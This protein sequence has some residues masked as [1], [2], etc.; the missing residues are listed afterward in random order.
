MNSKLTFQIH[1]GQ[2]VNKNMIGNKYCA[3]LDQDEKRMVD[4][5]INTY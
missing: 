4:V 2:N 1:G 5:A 3:S